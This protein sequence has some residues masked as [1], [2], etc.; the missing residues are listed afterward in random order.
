MKRFFLPLWFAVSTV[1]F[2]QGQP[3]Q[4]GWK[5]W[6]QCYFAR[7]HDAENTVAAGLREYPAQGNLQN[8]A[9]ALAAA[10]YLDLVMHRCLRAD[11]LF[12]TAQ[13]ILEKN[14]ATRDSNFLKI[15][16]WRAETMRHLSQYEAAKPL[17]KRAVALA[18]SCAG[19]PHG[20]FKSVILQQYAWLDRDLCLFGDAE[21]HY[22]QLIALQ[23]KNY[24]KSSPE[25]AIAQLNYANYYFSIFEYPKGLALLLGNKKNK[26]AIRILETAATRFPAEY[27][28]ALRLVGGQYIDSGQNIG[29]GKQFL[30]KSEAFVLKNLGVRHPQY[31]EVL[32]QQ[33]VYYQYQTIHFLRADTL[34][35]QALDIYTNLFGERYGYRIGVM[36]DIAAWYGNAGRAL[37]AAD[38]R[39]KALLLSE[40]LWGAGSSNANILRLSVAG[41]LLWAGQ[42]KDADSLV[43]LVLR[44]NKTIFGEMH[45]RYLEALKKKADLLN[46][47]GQ[48]KEAEDLYRKAYRISANISGENAYLAGSYLQ[49]LVGFYLFEDNPV[50]DSLINVHLNIIKNNLGESAA[51]YISALGTKS[52]YKGNIGQYGEARTAANQALQ[53]AERMLGKYSDTY[54]NALLILC[55]AIHD[56]KQ[57]EEEARLLAE[58]RQLVIAKYG[59]ASNH[60]LY[61][62]NQQKNLVG[63]TRPQSDLLPIKKEIIAVQ[64]QLGGA[65]LLYVMNLAD[66]AVGYADFGRYQAADSL[67]QFAKEYALKNIGTNDQFYTYVLYSFYKYFDKIQNYNQAEF[68]LNEYKKAYENLGIFDSGEQQFYLMSMAILRQNQGKIK[69]SEHIFDEWWKIITP[70]NTYGYYNLYAGLC[71]RKGQWQK[72]DSLYRL[73]LDLQI[74]TKGDTYYLY[75]NIADNYKQQG[76]PAKALEYQKIAMEEALQRLGEDNP[77]YFT[78]MSNYASLLADTDQDSLA[79]IIHKQVIS[80]T[81]RL[82]GVNNEA[83]T[84]RINNYAYSLIYRG[85][86]SEALDSFERSLEILG[87]VLGTDHPTYRYGLDNIRY[88]K[89]EL[90]EY[91][92]AE[93]LCLDNLAYWEKYAPGSVDHLSARLTYGIM[94]RELGDWE[95]AVKVFE[96]C[97]PEY[98]SL[99]GKN[100]TYYSGLLFKIGQV[101]RELFD[102]DAAL[103]LFRECMYYDSLNLGVNSRVYATDLYEYGLVL[104]KTGHLKPAEKMLEKAVRIREGLSAGK[105]QTFANMYKALSKAQAANN[106][107]PQALV[108]AQ[109][110]VAILAEDLGIKHEDYLWAVEWLGQLQLI[111]G[112]SAAAS[113]TLRASSEG[114]RE[115]I[116]NS[117]TY[118]STD[119]QQHFIQKYRPAEFYPAGNTDKIPEW[120]AALA[121]DEALLVKGAT[122]QNSKSIRQRLMRGANND[123]SKLFNQWLSA[124]SAINAQYGKRM[125]DRR[126]LDSLELDMLRLEKQLVAVSP[127]YAA[128]LQQTDVRYR[129]V[130]AALKPGMAAVEFIR[131]NRKM[132]WEPA[133]QYWYGALVLL[134]DAQAPVFLPLCQ[135]EQLP[136]ILRDFNKRE[137]GAV[138]KIYDIPTSATRSGPVSAAEGTNLYGLLWKPIDSLLQKSGVSSVYFAPAGLLHRINLGAIGFLEKNSTITRMVQ[139]YRLYQV[140]STRELAQKADFKPTGKTALYVGNIDYGATGPNKVSGNRG[141]SPFNPLIDAENILSKNT[142][143]FSKKGFSLITLQ[144]TE[145]NE[146]NVLK[147]LRQSPSPRCLVFE[148]H[149]FFLPEPD[150]SA[151]LHLYQEKNPMMRSGLVFAGVN[152]AVLQGVNAEPQSD[153][154]LTAQDFADLNLQQTE[155]VMLPVCNSGL[156][157]IRQGEGVFGL[158]RAFKKAGVQ[159][160]LMSLWEVPDPGIQLFTEE[161]LK[162]WLEKGL[163]PQEAFRA[164]QISLIEKGNIDPRIWAAMVLVN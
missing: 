134:P 85:R 7:Y 108:N 137:P 98:E 60:Y 49:S 74:Q 31:A 149:G 144:K 97:L 6:Q 43:D 139:I 54:L 117:F 103:R 104:L 79:D 129:Q 143:A 155:L 58:Y 53:L 156:G 158:Q 96:Q 67:I 133:D 151:L 66:L 95:K 71:S 112:Y 33:A 25:L 164:T 122:L 2:L 13:G 75:N 4:L 62:L 57:Y 131:Y 59:R 145:A 90:G 132:D 69:E 91:E 141:D 27:A 127:E 135:E 110:S 84:I 138:S 73:S 10:G 41:D 64:E 9:Y 3:E 50:A 106:R 16:N 34:Y 148:T 32:R 68:Y 38:W 87:K 150:S 118:L 116:R 119:Q 55:E 105:D 114:I 45:L 26:G 14:G 126:Q 154:V 136:R 12:Q 161:F 107:L 52:R 15:L 142:A 5:V 83:Y 30:D 61:Y 113:E 88:V 92:D 115:I 120:W 76:F 29:L 89:M 70:E 1:T 157:D 22:R 40:K 130:Q 21:Y 146:N 100:S 81:Q 51:P 65:G 56:L 128:Y 44:A 77:K 152:K 163:N 82:I 111:S 19:S 147:A 36:Q 72:A 47:K 102:F 109:K 42:R 20:K 140:G 63:E 124:Q 86:Y 18:D 23:E 123:A 159:Y 8:H 37:Q 11:S 17:L 160:V 48:K 162:Q 153:G 80:Q 39:R 121:Y 101:K 35:R 46:W 78:F 28:F 99:Y 24:G 125:A 94:H 93:R